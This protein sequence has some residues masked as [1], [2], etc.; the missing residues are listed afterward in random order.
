MHLNP[1]EVPIG[2]DTRDTRH[3]HTEIPLQ[4]GVPYEYRVKVS[5]ICSEL[6][7]DGIRGDIVTNRA[8]KVTLRLGGLSRDM[9][10]RVTTKEDYLTKPALFFC[11]SQVRT[12][13]LC[14][15]TFNN[16]GVQACTP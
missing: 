5:Q 6:N 4:V 9:R 11:L 3:I 15:C 16:A 8:A 14:W 13:V 10:S 2:W 7:V 12:M 1:P